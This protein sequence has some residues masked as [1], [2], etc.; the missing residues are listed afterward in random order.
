MFFA[1]GKGEGQNK[2]Q[3]LTNHQEGVQDSG[4][5]KR[6]GSDRRKKEGFSKKRT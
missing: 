5:Q 4:A 6:G 2:K 1:V 3:T